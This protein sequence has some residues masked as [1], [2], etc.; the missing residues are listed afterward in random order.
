MLQYKVSYLFHLIGFGFGLD[1]LNIQ[2]FLH[3]FF[4]E[5]MMASF[6]PFSKTKEDQ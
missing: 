5:N 3:I 1:F 4:G 6:D 2:N